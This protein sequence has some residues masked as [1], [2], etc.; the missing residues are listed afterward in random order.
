[1][2]LIDGELARTIRQNARRGAAERTI[3]RMVDQ[4]LAVFE[5]ALAAR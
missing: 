5:E 3:E 4:T 1:M 2:L